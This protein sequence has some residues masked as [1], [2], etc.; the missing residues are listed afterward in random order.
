MRHMMHIDRHL[1]GNH[2]DNH[3]RMQCHLQ[4]K[5]LLLY[6][7][8]NHTDLQHLHRINNNTVEETVAYYIFL[9]I[10]STFIN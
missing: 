2:Q 5:C 8:L 7:D 6:K 1:L 4:S 9:L 3:K 10:T